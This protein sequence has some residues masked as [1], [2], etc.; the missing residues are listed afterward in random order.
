MVFKKDDNVL[1][2][3]GGMIIP[4]SGIPDLA[5]NRCPGANPMKGIRYAGT[6]E[7][8]EGDANNPDG[9]KV[10]ARQYLGTKHVRLMQTDVGSTI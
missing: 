10:K 2:D 9:Y 4:F 5:L 3:Y 1:F 7:E 8:V 6:V